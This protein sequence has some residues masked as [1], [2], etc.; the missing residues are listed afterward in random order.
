MAL[1]VDPADSSM[2]SAE[3]RSYGLLADRAG[4]HDPNSRPLKGHHGAGRTAGQGSTVE[5]C[6]NSATKRDA[7]FGQRC[8]RWLAGKV[9]AGCGD[10]MSQSCRERACNRMWRYAHADSAVVA[11]QG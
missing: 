7:R 5:K 2:A 10:R 11:E 9:G 8:R 3:R 4:A 6:L 1:F